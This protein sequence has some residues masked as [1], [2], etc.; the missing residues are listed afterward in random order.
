MLSGKKSRVSAAGRAPALGAGGRGFKPRT[1]D[2]HLYHL[3]GGS[4][5]KNTIMACGVIVVLALLA[6][7]SLY[8]RHDGAKKGMAKPTTVLKYSAFIGIPLLMMA[9]GIM[10]CL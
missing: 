10:F 7:V 8:L 5:M 4:T 6:Y 3:K 1:F 2:Q 9:A